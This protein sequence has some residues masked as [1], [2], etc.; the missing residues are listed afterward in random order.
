MVEVVILFNGDITDGLKD[1]TIRVGDH[2]PST[3]M[4]DNAVCFNQSL[5][6]PL[7][8]LFGIR[9]RYGGYS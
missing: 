1:V 7:Q 4:N 5:T 8:G 3:N 9:A 6:V 2:D